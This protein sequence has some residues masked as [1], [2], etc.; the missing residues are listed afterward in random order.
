MWSCLMGIFWLHS[1]NQFIFIL[2][3]YLYVFCIINWKKYL[4]LP[5]CHLFCT[6]PPPPTSAKRSGSTKKPLNIIIF[7]F[8][9]IQN[10]N[11]SFHLHPAPLSTFSCF[12]AIT[13]KIHKF[14]ITAH[15][16]CNSSVFLLSL[17]RQCGWK[18]GGSVRWRCPDWHQWIPLDHC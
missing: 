5:F 7:F 11:S 12:N 18:N 9:I 17:V 10:F 8:L 14:S 3:S 15:K 1:K 13:W 2:S 4:A 16:D 6:N